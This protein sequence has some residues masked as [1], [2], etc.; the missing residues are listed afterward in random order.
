MAQARKHKTSTNRTELFKVLAL[1]GVIGLGLTVWGAL[2]AG[3]AMAGLEVNPNPP[4]ALLEAVSG[5]RPWPWQ[6]TMLMVVFAVVVV[7]IAVV[8]VRMRPKDRRQIDDAARTMASPR[9]LVE[10]TGKDAEKKS[11]RL[12][13]DAD[14][15]AHKKP[16]IELGP[17]V[18]GRTSIWM[19]WEDN[20]VGVGGQRTGKSAAVV[21]PTIA[22]A[23][24]ASLTCGNKPDVYQAT[25]VI[26]EERGTVW[27]FDLQGVTGQ[28]TTN[29]WWNPLRRI[30]RLGSAR[31]LAGF[32][33]SASKEP[34]A[35]ADAYF[36]GG[37]QELLALYIL[38]AAG[39]G[40]DL[41]H[42]VDWLGRDQDPT[43]A[44][45]LESTGK[46]RAAARIRDTQ[47]LTSKQRDGLYDMARRFLNVLSDDDYALA[48]TPPVRR[49]IIVENTLHSST[50]SATDSDSASVRTE[51][52]EY[53]HALP[54]FDPVAFVSSTDTLYALSMEG[55]DSTAPLTTALIGQV[56]AGAVELS[57][58]SRG[59][60]LKVPFVAMLDEAANICP[61][62]DLPKW[63][64]HFGSRGIILGTFLQS[65]KQGVRVWGKEDTDAMIAGAIHYYGG[66]VQD[67]DYLRTLSDLVGTHEV[68]VESRNHG[69]GSNSSSLSYRTEPILSVKDLAALP[70]DRALVRFPK[71][72]PV[73][74]RK[75]FYFNGPHAAK[76][77][78][79]NEKY[80]NPEGLID[81]DLDGTVTVP[82]DV[83]ST[84]EPYEW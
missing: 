10:M 17:L 83:D 23:P 45:I 47:A 59:G 35:R 49:K 51:T 3:S 68:P 76:I 40:G 81:V 84:D 50:S 44:V 78:E 42:V 62:K 64:S 79:S 66:N 4:A 48:V 6:S 34:G 65:T 37:A 53:M 12:R 57:L 70:G 16:G 63:Y 61:L 75:A 5:R 22:E 25:R 82:A 2:S 11:R 80:G 73:L 19:S 60:R 38:A 30:E 74:I 46:R 33:V 71:N 43:P 56:L 26:C 31:E 29:F 41:L 55:P 7:A 54:E 36:D 77:Q 27:L 1:V 8:V 15:S 39:V 14:P 24:G 72:P 67:T 13:P 28:R 69:S 32:F 58:K 52:G 20:L 18:W 21:I 9:E